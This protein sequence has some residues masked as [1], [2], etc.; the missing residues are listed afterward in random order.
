VNKDT[1]PID[2]IFKGYR[3]F[4]VQ[5]LVFNRKVTKYRREFYETPDG[6]TVVAELPK[7]LDGQSSPNCC[8]NS[9]RGFYQLSHQ[10]K[11]ACMQY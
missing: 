4:F 9:L 1:L 10:H 2:S 11:A 7:D 5:D 3:D 8:V 6:A